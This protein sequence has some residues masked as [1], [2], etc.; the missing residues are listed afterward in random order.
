MPEAHLQLLRQLK[1]DHDQVLLCADGISQAVL[2][3]EFLAMQ[4]LEEAW[5]SASL[6]ENRIKG[7]QRTLLKALAVAAVIKC[8][9][10]TL[11]RNTGWHPDTAI[12]GAICTRTSLQSTVLKHCRAWYGITAWIV[13]LNA[14]QADRSPADTVWR[15]LCSSAHASQHGQPA[16]TGSRMQDVNRVTA[17]CL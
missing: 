1:S 9:W 13:E 6:L 3:A 4:A 14:V 2:R 12:C 17:G 8:A 11:Q 16:W 15:A 7:S 5:A 10:P